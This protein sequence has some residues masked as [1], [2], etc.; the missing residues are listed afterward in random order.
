MSLQNWAA[1]A[2]ANMLNYKSS[3]VFSGMSSSL[4]SAT[5]SK[6]FMAGTKEFAAK[7]KDFMGK[8]T[9]L[10]RGKFGSNRGSVGTGK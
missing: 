2:Q 8:S 7:S 9:A 4:L 10:F 3:G 6:A 1:T 5:D